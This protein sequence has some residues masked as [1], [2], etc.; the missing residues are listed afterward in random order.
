MLLTA[1]CVRVRR[2]RVNGELGRLSNDSNGF[3][4]LP[5]CDW[6][7]RLTVESRFSFLVIIVLVHVINRGP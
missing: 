2:E 7:S 1:E 3:E 4:S 5:V 6:K